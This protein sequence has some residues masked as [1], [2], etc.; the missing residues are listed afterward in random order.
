MNGATE[1]DLPQHREIET[2]GRLALRRVPIM[3]G[4]ATVGS[5]RQLI[6][7]SDFEAIDLVLLTDAEGRYIGAVDLH[8]LI[9]SDDE[10][11]LL[12]VVRDDWP[13]VPPEMD[14]EHAAEQAVSHAVTVLPVVAQDGCP[15]GLMPASVLIDVLGRE[16]REDV[17]RMAGILRERAGA[18]HALE[19][20]PMSRVA[21]RLPWLLVGLAMSSVATGVMAGFEQTLQSN[22]MIAFFIPALVYLTDAI[23]TQ[24]EAIAVRGLSVRDEPLPQLLVSEIITGGA[25]GLLL[26]VVAFVSVWMTFGSLSVAAGVGISLFAAGTMASGLG[27]LFPWTLSR[28]GV[29]PAFGAGPVATIVQDV[30]TIVIYFLVMTQLIGMGV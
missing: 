4:R 27:L 18:R 24:T 2:A 14:Q 5:V 13:T 26:G 9:V 15:I 12:Q 29:D 7:S 22:V 10:T 1:L 28:L 3:P 11:E 6:Q 17:H 25:I 30:L 23:G 21:R 16:H 20:P 8:R 19:D